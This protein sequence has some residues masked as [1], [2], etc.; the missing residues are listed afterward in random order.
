MIYLTEIV[1]KLN[2][3]IVYIYGAG[4]MG[5]ALLKCI[6]ESD[7][8][9]EVAGFLVGEKGNNPDYIDNIPIK[10]LE[11]DTEAKN[12][13]ILIALHEKHINDALDT[14]LSNGYKD[15][16]PITF[17]CDE[18][19]DI[20]IK[21]LMCHKEVFPFE[22][23]FLGENE[24]DVVERSWGDI[25]VY[26][27]RSVHDKTIRVEEPRPYEKY[28]QVGSALTDESLCELC[29][30]T[31]DNISDKNIRYCELT[32]LYWAWKNDV[33]SE[34][35]GISHYRRRFRLS[36]QVLDD[37]SGNY[38]DFILTVP[39]V[40]FDT[41]RIQFGRDHSEDIWKAVE[42]VVFE[43][44]PEYSDGLK[45]VGEGIIYFGYNMFI[46]KRKCF[47]DYAEWL[48]PILF[49]C[50]RRIGDIEDRYQNRYAGFIAERLLL[51]YLKYNQS[52]YKVAVA[53]KHFDIRGVCL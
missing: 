11:E 49:G 44:C 14:L 16:Y 6:R 3:C 37:I 43:I 36:D 25:S 13:R 21:W 19:C 40:N 39:I 5:K 31:G 10:T 2:N 42:K 24:S 46:A 7:I 38:F 23:Y 26:V 22:I 29:D 34:Y 41:V 48:F 35:K 18:W 32:A 50:E 12:S 28:I 20:R 1:E 53:N 33:T 17:D 9:C 8:D 27:A 30:D 51:V 15:L 4:L 52:K 45:E 47:D